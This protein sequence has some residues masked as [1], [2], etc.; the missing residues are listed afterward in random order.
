MRASGS[1]GYMAQP[2]TAAAFALLASACASAWS[3]PAGDESRSALE[4]GRTIFLAR[5]ALCHGPEADGNGQ[6][7]RLLDPRPADLQHSVLTDA[8]RN[9][10]VRHGGAAMGRS[11]A[12]PRW[13]VELE[14][15]QLS[16]V[17]AFVATVSARGN[18][19]TAP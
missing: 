5:C 15:E 18:A 2:I 1:A 13:E 7:A 8:Q 19:R 4:K 12:M 17:I 6:M 11:A 9:D 14:E 16:N 10:I 3:A